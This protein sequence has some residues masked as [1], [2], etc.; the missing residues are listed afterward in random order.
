MPN[1]HIVVLTIIQPKIVAIW[2]MSYLVSIFTLARRNDKIRGGAIKNL[3]IIHAPPKINAKTK[4]SK[5]KIKARK[6]K[7]TCSFSAI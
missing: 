2:K 1:K 6:P 7:L 4:I 3:S 5:P